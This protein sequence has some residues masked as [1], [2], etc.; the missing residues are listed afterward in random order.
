MA[1]RIT[2]LDTD[3][4]AAHQ[5][6]ASLDAM[7]GLPPQ[8]P[9]P[10]VRDR[11]PFEGTLRRIYPG[12]IVSL[13]I[14][15]AATWLSAHYKA[16][17]MLYALLLGMAFHFLHEEGA[18]VAGIEF[19]SKA[20][21]R[22]GV[23]LLGAKIT[24]EQIIGLGVM[25]IV[26]VVVGVAT[27]ILLGALLAKRLGL[28]G[29]FGVLTGGAVAICG[30]SA[31]LALASVLPKTRD[32][33]R[34]TILTVVTITA[35]ST[36]AMIVYP[37]IAVAVGFDHTHAGIFIG[38]T[39]HDVAQV[40]GAGYS[41]SPETGDTATYVKLLRVSM[42]VPVVFT[43]AMLAR[44][45]NPAMRGASAKLPLFLVGFV[46]LVAINS[47][48]WLPAPVT[49]FA[50]D[51]SRWCLATAISALGMKTS[52][53]ALAAVGWRPIA[54]MVTETLWIGVLVLL[55]VKFIV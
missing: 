49:G 52:F 9:S 53:K 43:V 15:V 27:T 30:A 31:A 47:L 41:I 29:A 6:F 16:P 26:I 18:C 42:L 35:L 38:G 36:I 25:P 54:L 51:L 1:G 3:T 14:A 28:S 24:A 22:V 21:L 23:A 44:R 11:F 32:S 50:G 8:A 20:V 12:L 46:A 7:E 33:E 13:T 4:A 2:D 17:L 34:D 10:V 48:G 19:S 5:L 45:G 37:L 55:A 39:I 40:V